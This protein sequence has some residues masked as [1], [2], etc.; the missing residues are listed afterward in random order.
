MSRR[1]SPS[2]VAVAYAAFGVLWIAVSD[3]LLSLIVDSPALLVR[4][5]TVKGFGF[6]LFT[7]GLLYFLLKAKLAPPDSPSP[8]GTFSYQ[9][10]QRYFILTFLGLAL[11]A[12]LL[13]YGIYRVHSPQVEREAL[14]NLTAIARLKVEEIEGWLAERDGDGFALATSRGFADLVQ[15]GAMH[16]DDPGSVNRLLERLENLRT[17][18]A[19]DQISVFSPEGR[20]L[21]VAGERGVMPAAIKEFMQRAQASRT[22]TRTE[23]D[24]DEDGTLHLD[25]IVPIVFRDAPGMPLAGTVVLHVEPERYLFPL[26]QT[27]P[28]VSGSGESLLVRRDGNFVLFINKLRHRDDPPLSL[29]LPLDLQLPAARAIATDGSGVMRGIDYRGNAVLAAFR[30]VQGTNWRLL[31]KVDRDEVLAPVLE[32]V[33]WVSLFAFFTVAFTSMALLMLWQQRQRSHQWEMAAHAAGAVAE[34]EAKLRAIVDNAPLTIFMKDPEGRYLLINRNYQEAFHIAEQQLLGKLDRDLFPE[35]FADAFARNDRKVLESQQPLQFE[36]RLPHDDGV[37]TYLSIKFPVRRLSGEIYAVCG[38]A[39]DISERKQ[40]E[41]KIER[42]SRVYAAL[43]ECNQAIVRC[44]DEAELFAQV[45]RSA[46]QHVGVELAWVGLLEAGSSRVVPVAWYGEGEEYLRD[47]EIT[48]DEGSALGRGPGGIAIRT[49]QACWFDNFLKDARTLPWHERAGRHSWNAVA[50]LPVRQ[51]GEVVGIFSLYAREMD[52]FD[53]DVRGLFE[54][55]ATDISFALDNFKSER[56][57]QRVEDELRKSQNL[58]HTLALSAPVGIFRADRA[59]RCIFVNQTWRDLTGLASGTVCGETWLEL[60]AEEDLPQVSRA[61]GECLQNG[62]SFRQDFRLRA[63][64]R[65]LI[66]VAGRAEAERDAAGQITGILGTVTDITEL[67][68]Q[69]ERLRQ[70]LVVFENSREGILVTDAEERIVLM[71][72]A[73]TEM[74]GYTMEESMGLT[75]RFLKSG[76]HDR[77]FYDRLWQDL[78]QT[79]HWQGEIWNRRKSGEVF[80]ELVS[81]STVKD[82]SGAVKQFVGIFSDISQIKDAVDKLDFLAHHDP[83][84]GLPNRLVLTSRLQHSLSAAKRERKRL[85]LLMLDLDRFK[86]VNDSFGHVAGDELLRQVAERL[87]KRLRGADTVTRLGGDEFTVLLED[88]AQPQDAAHV[89]WDIIGAMNEPWR[90]S[91]GLEVRVGTSVGIALYPEHGSTSEDL[92]QHADAALYR[93]KDEGRGNFKYFSDE[94]TQAA[95]RRISLESMLRRAIRQQN[96]SVHYQPQ[97]DIASGAIVGAEAL[98]RWT[99]PEEGRIPPS[100]FISVA[101]QT[102][103]IGEI[104]EWVLR[105]TCRQGRAWLDSGLPPLNLAVNLSMHQFRYGDIRHTVAAVLA[106]TRFPAA[107]LELE[108][109]ESALMDRESDVVELLQGLRALNVRLAIDD[110]GTGY[111]S[112]AY[113]KRFPLNV[114]KIDKSFIEDIPV[115]TGDMEIAAAIIA[116]GHIL[117]L[118]VVAEGVETLDQLAF[119]REK[120]CD[121]FQGYLRSPPIPAEEFEKLFA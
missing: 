116:L 18:Y 5:S 95:R 62:R 85:A 76:R 60:V 71:N 31:A 13:G 26:I 12:P 20:T 8:T 78:L 90:L 7:A 86:D 21:A 74:T 36:E 117:R 15:A 103:L 68:L 61:W 83:L 88:L 32:L 89:A 41:T 28:T 102:G 29:R 53:P 64:T 19:Y 17:A 47:L 87:A 55:M 51:G 34:S 121:L 50:A 38:I 10:G 23:I 4:I 94:L 99:D 37:H 54:E 24:R 81:I 44:L 82:E 42:L 110:F 92:L 105:E 63:S 3:R 91:N 96:L 108:L 59:G 115:H 72:R 14:S 58:F 43:S 33:V 111:S 109:T 100:S 46:V 77:S 79:G 119:L 70:A 6:V 22:V 114:L 30:P 25:W 35:T 16:P 93:A 101:E 106:E 1:F 75:P 52:T 112:L 48:A 120:G 98:L 57:R 45:C 11:G 66:W 65:D 104:G 39:A 9:R 56:E 67:K 97:Y 27:W 69:Q 73:F 40:A 107:Y 84:T 2:A 113:L 80:P 49:G 118:R